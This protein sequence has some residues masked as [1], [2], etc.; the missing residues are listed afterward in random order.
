MNP[1]TNEIQ[2]SDTQTGQAPA[3][4]QAFRFHVSAQL[5]A[6]AHVTVLARTREEA[7]ARVQAQG[8][9]RYSGLTDELRES[10][11][12][13]IRKEPLDLELS[14]EEVRPATADD[15]DLDIG[16]TEDDGDDDAGT[17]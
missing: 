6:S 3:P 8:D 17:D 9:L 4:L 13:Q 1:D 2:T 12:E 11:S 16:D 7:E 5:C 15:A 10:V 14:L